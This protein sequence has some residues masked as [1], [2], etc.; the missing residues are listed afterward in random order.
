MPSLGIDARTKLLLSNRIDQF[1]PS[2]APA[3]AAQTAVS[4]SPSTI[5][6]RDT[7]TPGPV[8]L[9]P[10]KVPVD[11]RILAYEAFLQQPAPQRDGFPNVEEYNQAYAYYSQRKSELERA[12]GP[13][14]LERAE[15]RLAQTPTGAA[16][17]EAGRETGREVKVLPDDE[18]RLRFPGSSGVNAEDG[19][20]YFP[21][22]SVRG[23][24]AQSIVAHEYTHAILGDEL[25]VGDPQWVREGRTAG[26][27]NEIG[28]NPEDGRQIAQQTEGWE[29]EVAAEHV[30]THVI[31]HDIAREQAGLPPESP[32]ERAEFI[33]RTAQ[34]ELAINLRDRAKSDQGYT[35]KQLLEDWADTPQ[36][37][38]NPPPGHTDAERAA[39]LRKMLEE[40]ASEDYAP[41]D[42]PHNKLDP[43]R[44]GGK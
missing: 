26:R 24:D 17:L 39:N 34:H 31:E 29:N 44:I 22:S 1:R 5:A 27:F 18:Y 13:A 15:Q 10:S 11:P 12:A 3:T 8:R 42:P 16:I 9:G 43:T 2:A 14:Y 20:I 40:Y 4:R 21:L 38:A 37:Q 32:K 6:P 33:E 25:D 36:G 19:V 30:A 28:L 35:D 7:F 41:I 23:D